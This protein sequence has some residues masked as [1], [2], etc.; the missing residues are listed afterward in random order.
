MEALRRFHRDYLVIEPETGS[1]AS[2]DYGSERLSSKD[3]D[4]VKPAARKW[5]WYHIGWVA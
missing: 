1:F 2:L 4:P 5:R 3:L